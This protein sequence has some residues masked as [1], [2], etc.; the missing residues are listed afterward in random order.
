VERIARMARKEVV[1]RRRV[2]R[3]RT[4][5][6]GRLMDEWTSALVDPAKPPRWPLRG[7]PGM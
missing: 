2:G 5:G 1:S 7:S 4:G 6:D 3:R